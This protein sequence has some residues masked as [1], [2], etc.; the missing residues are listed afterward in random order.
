MKAEATTVG[1]KT[2]RRMK[3][4]FIGTSLSTKHRLTRWTTDGRIVATK[5]S[6]EPCILNI[7]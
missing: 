2:D 5:A 1:E 4:C 7:I 3:Q 6:C